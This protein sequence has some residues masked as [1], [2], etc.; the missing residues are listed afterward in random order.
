[1][2]NNRRLHVWMDG[3]FIGILQMSA[4]GA[5]SFE[6][7][8]E[9]AAN[10]AATPL[11]LSMPL[12][13]RNFGNR[14]VSAFLQGLLPDN[15]NALESMARKYQV[16][17]DSPFAML[18]HVGRDVAG[19]LQ[20]IGPEEQSDDANA[21]RAMVTALDD[22]ALTQELHNVI[23]TYDNGALFQGVQRMSLA[24]TQAKLGV[25]QTKDG[26]WAL[27]SHG[28]PTTHI[29]KPQR[30]GQ[31]SFPESDIVELFCQRVVSAAGIPAASQLCGIQRT[32]R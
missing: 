2:M 17:K 26:G 11:S 24:G 19:A 3:I 28:V 9:Y 29:F 27:P 20:I 7:D 14:V 15:P 10:P 13:G 4:T 16:S 18:R 21:D 22:A 31:T 30:V 8:S 6:Y 5:L 12:Q 32:D 23:N 1:A 25:S